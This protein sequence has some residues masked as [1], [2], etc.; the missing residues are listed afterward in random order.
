MQ[1]FWD[2]GSIVDVIVRKGSPHS[3]PVTCRLLERYNPIKANRV[4]LSD[5]V[6][7]TSALRESV[8]RQSAGPW[9]E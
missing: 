5:C 9:S 6:A 1:P 2:R 4:L 7:L 3:R 8:A